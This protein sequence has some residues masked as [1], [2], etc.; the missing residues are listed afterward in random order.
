METAAAALGV[1][2][3]EIG[4]REAGDAA[5]FSFPDPRPVEGQKPQPGS[6]K[7]QT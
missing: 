1:R 7:S 3:R 2:L 6:G 5:T 4:V